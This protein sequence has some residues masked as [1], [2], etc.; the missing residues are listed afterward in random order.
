MF[1]KLRA[2]EER[3]EKLMTLVSDAAIQAD[4]AEYRTHTSFVSCFKLKRYYLH[5]RRR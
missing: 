1:D 2:V 5:L 4:A 3:Y